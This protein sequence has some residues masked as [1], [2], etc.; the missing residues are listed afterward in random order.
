MLTWHHVVSL[1]RSLNLLEWDE[2]DTGLLG[3]KYGGVGAAMCGD[4]LIRTAQT[5]CC[6]CHL[7]R[8]S[9]S[10]TP[11][12]E[13]IKHKSITEELCPIVVRYSN[14]IPRYASL[15]HARAGRE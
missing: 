3:G 12:H 4:P 13:R 6:R 9:R 14:Y 8:H 1:Q 15:S 2:G 11:Y 10:R 5:P 7:W